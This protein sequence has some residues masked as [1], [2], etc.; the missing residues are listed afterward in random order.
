MKINLSVLSIEA[1]R[2]S[3]VPQNVT[4]NN[5]STVTEVK[6]SETALSVMFRFTSNYEPN[7]GVIK[8]EGELSLEDSKEKI[9][10][11]FEQWEKSGNK[12][13]PKD[14]AE[15]VHNTILVNCIVEATVLSREV[16]LPAPFPTPKIMIP[17]DK[18]DD[19]DDI[20]SYIR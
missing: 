2:I 20:N 11:I 17:D 7:V 5:N 6:Q 19:E 9:E 3:D 13:L 16:R 10:S 14:I 8:I 18:K 1:R 4:I 15:K 12:N